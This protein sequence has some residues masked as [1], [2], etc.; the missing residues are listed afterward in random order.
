MEFVFNKVA[1]LQTRNVIKKRL[2]HSCFL[3]NFLKFLRAAFVNAALPEA[4]TE[5]QYKANFQIKV[6]ISKVEITLFEYVMTLSLF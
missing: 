4:A 2:Q 3:L 5:L 1:R 6:E